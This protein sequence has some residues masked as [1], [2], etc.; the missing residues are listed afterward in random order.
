MKKRIGIV[1]FTKMLIKRCSEDNITQYAY[2]LTYALLLSFFPFLIFLIT[3]IG[4]SQLDSSVVL[5]SLRNFLPDDVYNLISGIVIE[6]VDN[7]QDGLM[8]FSIIFAIFSASGGFRA[9]MRASNRAMRIEEKR[10]IIVQYILSIFWVILLALG[11]ILALLGIVFGE[12]LINL[13]YKFFTSAA[14]SKLLHVFRI[15]IPQIFIFLLFLSFYMFV[16]AEKICFRCAIT[17]TVFTTS[18]WIIFT[19]GFQY[20]VNNFANYSRFYGTLGAVVALMLWL[21]LTSI[22]ML[23][24]VEI[25]ALLMELKITTSR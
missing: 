15:I 1:K 21:S 13:T 7:Q 11:I 8:S 16:P 2:H 24:G 22:I 17:G 25:N 12:Y 23:I 5:T 9:F 20:Y 14:S 3:L 6:V 10:N 4:Y 18:A 19:M